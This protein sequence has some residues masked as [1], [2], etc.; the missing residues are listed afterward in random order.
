MGHNLQMKQ[1]TQILSRKAF[2]FVAVNAGGYRVWSAPGRLS[3]GHWVKRVMNRAI[4]QG[5]W[6]YRVS[7]DLTLTP[8]TIISHYLVRWEVG[9]FYRVAKQPLGWGGYRMHDLF[10]IER[11]VQLMMVA[12]AYLELRRQEALASAA[13]ADAR[14]TLGDIQRQLQSLARRTEIARVFYLVQRGFSLE[15]IC[16]RLAA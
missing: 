13:D 6:R 9:N 8:Q 12:H 10:A 11:H 14:V 16:Q 3:S 5:R 15:M 4:G 2:G 7:T 1:W